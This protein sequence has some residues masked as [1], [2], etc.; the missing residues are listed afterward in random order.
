MARNA[1][2]RSGAKAPHVPKAPLTVPKSTA[3]AVSK[4]MSLPVPPLPPMPLRAPP[5]SPSGPGAIEGAG[6][7]SGHSVWSAPST[8]PGTPPWKAPPAQAPSDR[9]EQ[10]PGSPPW[11]S[12]PGGRQVPP[13]TTW[14]ESQYGSAQVAAKAT[15]PSTPALPP[16][17]PT[18]AAAPKTPPLAVGPPPKAGGAPQEGTA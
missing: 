13:P 3:Q 15:A 12:P 1:S 16:P 8:P 7:N 14:E 2:M 9:A 4:A 11:R 18:A 6:A 10:A 17:A 5:L